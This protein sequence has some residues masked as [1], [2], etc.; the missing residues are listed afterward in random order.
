VQVLLSETHICI[1]GNGEMW[2]LLY[3]FELTLRK[4]RDP[5]GR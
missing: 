2:Y 3:E 5:D 1:S 4:K